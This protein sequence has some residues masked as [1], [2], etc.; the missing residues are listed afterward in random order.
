MFLKTAFQVILS[1]LNSL[2][3]MCERS[4]RLIVLLALCSSPGYVLEWTSHSPRGHQLA[5]CNLMTVNSDVLY[6]VMKCDW[7]DAD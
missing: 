2:S 7:S 5:G 4:V 1:A 3:Y 6:Y